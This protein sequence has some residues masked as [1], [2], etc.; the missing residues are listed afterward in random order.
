[1]LE[2]AADMLHISAFHSDDDYEGAKKDK[3]DVDPY[4]VFK[5]GPSFSIRTSF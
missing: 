4:E 2:T 3:M 1:V 5:K